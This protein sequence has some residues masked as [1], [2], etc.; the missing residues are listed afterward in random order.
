MRILVTG[1][2]GF[3]GRA[4]CEAAIARGH[5]VL[6]L[7]REVNARLPA[8]CQIARG[9][10]EQFPWHDMGTFKPAVVLHSAWVATPGVY[11]TSPEND[12]LVETSAA[13]FRGLAARGVTHLAGLGTCIEY[14]AS[15][16]PLHETRS[17]PGPTFPYSRAKFALFRRLQ[18]L[19]T[20]LRLP[21]T[22]FRLF[23]PYGPGEHPS[24]IST[25]I[26]QQLRAGKPVTLRTP[27]SFKDY[28]YITD[29]AH[30]L[31]QGLEATI[32]G[33][34]NVGSGSG[35]SIRNLARTI[36]DLMIADP[37][38]I[39]EA[40]QI[41]HDPTPSVIA[42]TTLINSTGWIPAVPL[43]TGL[44]NLISSLA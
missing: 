18:D 4:F 31:C 24:R 2:T 32:C 3:V 41:A 42:D 9:S 34:V 39:R 26:I 16:T 20:E 29:L 8:G 13:L 28:V 36:A 1:A 15:E 30:A 6:G 37:S 27:N 17:L 5:K 33:P 21:W 25:H 38:L 43:K 22:W 19:G 14:A 11:L 23:Y 12:A 10:L 7:C 35:T 40:G 44:A